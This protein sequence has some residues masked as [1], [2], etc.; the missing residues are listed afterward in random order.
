MNIFLMV[1]LIVTCK[2]NITLLIC[3][4]WL[5][6]LLGC[7]EDDILPAYYRILDFAF[8]EYQPKEK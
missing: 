1:V 6:I 4:L 7:V 5:L 8:G 3:K 2:L